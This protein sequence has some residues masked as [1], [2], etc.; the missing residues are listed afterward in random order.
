MPYAVLLAV[1]YILLQKD[2]RQ[3]KSVTRLKVLLGVNVKLFLQR[4]S[5]KIVI[6]NI[7]NCK[8]YY[9]SYCKVQFMERWSNITILIEGGFEFPMKIV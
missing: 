3:S 2:E 7:H 4:I 9:V 1:L 5:V 6:F 8:I